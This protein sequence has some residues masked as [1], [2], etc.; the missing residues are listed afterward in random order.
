VPTPAELRA[1]LEDVLDPEYP[2]SVVDLGLVRD[3]ELEGATAHVKL[4]YCSLGCPCTELILED[5]EARLLRVAGVECVEIE[6]VFDTW[7]LARVSERG[8]TQLRRAGV[9]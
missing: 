8:R 3:I 5:I 1:A 4:A 6:E 2:V 9:A 7:T